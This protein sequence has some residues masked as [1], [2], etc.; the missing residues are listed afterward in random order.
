M[1]TNLKIYA[2]A[3]NV[4]LLIGKDFHCEN[5]CS[6]LLHKEHNLSVSIGDD[7]MFGTNIQL[8]TSDAHTIL[9]KNTK[10]V[11]NT[12]GSINIGNHVWLAKDVTVLKNVNISDGCIVGTGSIVTKSLNDKDSLYV[13]TPAK[14][15][16]SDVE[17]LMES[18]PQYLKNK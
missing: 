10:E 17:W 8:R 15:V 6:I 4:S 11:L 18:I 2:T 16:K 9:D 7:C 14:K 5:N 3:D 13:G 12:G 1:A